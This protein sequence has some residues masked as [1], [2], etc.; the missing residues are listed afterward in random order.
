MAGPIGNGGHF[1]VK[2]ALVCSCVRPEMAIAFGNEGQVAGLARALASSGHEVLYFAPPFAPRVESF[3]PLAPCA[4]GVPIWVVEGKTFNT[5]E[6]EL[7]SADFVLDFSASH[8]VAEEMYFWGRDSWKGVLLWFQN[9]LDF[10]WP[11]YPA[12][13]HWD[14]VVYNLAQKQV[15]TSFTKGGPTIPDKLHILPSGVDE[16]LYTLPSTSSRES[17]LHFVRPGREQDVV[18]LIDLARK[19]PEEKFQFALGDFSTAEPV[20]LNQQTLRSLKG[21]PNIDWIRFDGKES[22]RLKLLQGAR[23]LLITPSTNPVDCSGFEALTSLACGTPV[24]VRKQRAGPD[25]DL[26]GNGFVCETDD[27][28]SRAIL[29]VE[30]LDR[31]KCREFVTSRFTC[32]RWAKQVLELHAS[33]AQ[34]Q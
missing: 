18:A 2:I 28:Y 15:A 16:T 25:F 17:F 13:L 22:S 10:N 7:L 34:E 6:A 20:G 24:V 1:Y 29:G 5:W 11:R 21:T 19:H 14:G 31:S 3:R 23:A 27:D 33:L 32:G 26:D 4:S 9:G 8:R 30:S 12:N